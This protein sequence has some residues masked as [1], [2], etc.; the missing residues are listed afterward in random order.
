MKTRTSELNFS[1]LSRLN[2]AFLY[3]ADL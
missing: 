1:I 3:D 2:T